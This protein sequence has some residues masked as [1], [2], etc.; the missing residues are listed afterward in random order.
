MRS[1]SYLSIIS[2]FFVNLARSDDPPVIPYCP[3]TW[4]KSPSYTSQQLKLW[5]SVSWLDAVITSFPQRTSHKF[6]WMP[7]SIIRRSRR[8]LGSIVLT[9]QISTGEYVRRYPQ[10]SAP[11]HSFIIKTHLG[12]DG[13][14]LMYL[15]WSR[16]IQPLLWSLA[17]SQARGW[18]LRQ[19][20]SEYCRWAQ[21]NF[22]AS[23]AT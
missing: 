2:A 14:W 4:V 10:F 7:R 12:A 15:Q 22:G 20:C 13:F 18:L 16:E 11:L 3:D 1:I 23:I 6:W 9:V 21:L 17:A 19:L 5:Q 8:V